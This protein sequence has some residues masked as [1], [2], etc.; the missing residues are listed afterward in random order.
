MKLGIMQPYFMPYIG[1]FQL[2]KAVEIYVVLDDVNYINRGWLNRNNILVNGVKNLFTI[3][4]KGATQN[5]LINEIEIEDD[6][7][8]LV[9]TIKINYGKAP[10]YKDV[11]L[12]VERILSYKNKGLS[13]FVINSL[14]EIISYLHIDTQILISSKLEKDCSLK[15]QDRILNICSALGAD[16]FINAIGGQKLY[17]KAEFASCGVDLKFIQTELVPYK[18]LKN[19]FIPFLSILDVMMFNSVEE[20][21]VMLDK[22]DLI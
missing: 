22:Y 18:Q 3:K 20:V 2:I 17:D 13:E 16:V 8:K 21:N 10:F 15:C 7:L 9:K 11:I 12:L 19:E 1:Y 6:F 14:K 5:K 4:L